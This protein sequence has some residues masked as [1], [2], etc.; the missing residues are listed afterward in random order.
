[1]AEIGSNAV[2][3]CDICRELPAEG[4]GQCLPCL[5]A[6][7]DLE[8][9]RN[10]NTLSDRDREAMFQASRN[11]YVKTLRHNGWR[12]QSFFPEYSEVTI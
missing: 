7:Q 5:R 8:D 4:D 2:V 3:F 1:M 11:Y 9:V 12:H 6:A 10:E